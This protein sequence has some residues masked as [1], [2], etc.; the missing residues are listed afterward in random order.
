MKYGIDIHGVAD[1]KKLFFARFSERAIANGHEVHIITG[2]MRTPEIEKELSG[3]GI[4]FTH[5][6]SVS[7]TLLADG[8]ETHWTSP[9]DPWFKAEEW[10]K[11]KA[12]Y[13]KEN[14]IDL[15]FDDSNDYGKYFETP[16]V[17]VVI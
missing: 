11:A 13:C 17:K 7:D 10:N 12:D 4:E 6:F 5:F 16:Y 2:N 9:N 1:T 14:K 15:H 3:Y 8:K